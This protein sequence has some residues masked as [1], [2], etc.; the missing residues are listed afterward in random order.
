MGK[1]IY[2]AVIYDR[3]DILLYRTISIDRKEAITRAVE[4]R[5]RV[6]GI[7]RKSAWAKIKRRFGARVTKI[8]LLEAPHN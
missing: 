1:K 7:T 4:I 5:C 8:E 2:W 6:D 3:Y